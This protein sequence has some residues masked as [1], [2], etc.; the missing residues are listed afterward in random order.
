MKRKKTTKIKS[1][2]KKQKKIIIKHTHTRSNILGEFNF[3]ALK[4]KDDGS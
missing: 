4:N 1:K 2:N 3:N